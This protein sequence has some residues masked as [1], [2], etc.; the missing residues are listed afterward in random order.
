MKTTL[1]AFLPIFFILLLMLSAYFCTEF[2]SYKYLIFYLVSIPAI[3]G[4]FISGLILAI[5]NIGRDD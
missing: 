3:I 1:Y 2:R 5:R 4:L